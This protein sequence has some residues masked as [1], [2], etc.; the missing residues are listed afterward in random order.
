MSDADLWDPNTVTIANDTV[1]NSWKVC[2]IDGVF[3]GGN[4]YS[5]GLGAR[6]S[7]IFVILFVSM[8]FTLFPVVARR[9]P[10]LRIPEYAYLA[11][12]NFGSGVIVATGFVHL[13]DPAYG[14]IGPNSCVGM[15]GN[16]AQ[17][18]WVEAINLVTIFF[19]FGLDLL[20]SVYVEKKFGITYGGDVV[21]DA[22]V[23][24]DRSQP[25]VY[26]T[27]ESQAENNNDET[28][29]VTQ[30]HSSK[31]RQYSEEG[32]ISETTI[33]HDF[34]SQIAAFFILEFGVIF[35]SVNVGLLLGIAGK[36][37]KTLYPVLVFHQSFEGLG[38]GS[39]LST[40]PFPKDKRWWP[41][42]LCIAFGL[43]TPLCVAIGLGVRTT[44]DNNSYTANIVEGVLDA[45]SAGILIYTGLV[46]LLAR[47]FIYDK[48]R[49]KT[50]PKLLFM[51]TC[52]CLGTGLMAL[53][54]KWA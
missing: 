9:V 25:D 35:H 40:I 15:T 26:N 44:Y 33:L 18:T 16:W 6:I 7:S 17:Y 37:F 4:D 45:V 47:D 32:S 41:Y 8:A 54:G 14:H 13:L 34:E 11:A 43:T 20:S 5:G 21:T 3:F 36:N 42:A 31:D 29:V 39:R 2:V 1:P 50:I 28:G 10:S 52:V 22:I 24:P 30:H 46:E 12:K 27:K 53:L 19:T 38:I 48:N 23:R 49:P 51:L